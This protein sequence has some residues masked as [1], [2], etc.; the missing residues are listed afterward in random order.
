M[1]AAK[2]EQ[3]AAS[4]L[5]TG[6]ALLA[7]LA[8]AS[9]AACKLASYPPE[10][11]GPEETSALPAPPED[12][13]FMAAFEQDASALPAPREPEALTAATQAPVAA[14]QPE[15]KLAPAAGPAPAATEASAEA[16]VTTPA[17]SQP[18][19]QARSMT[20]FM[21]FSERLDYG[22]PEESAFAAA[23]RRAAAN[24]YEDRF[25]RSADAPLPEA[26]PVQIA[27]ETAPV[28]TPA[29]APS[30]AGERSVAEQIRLNS[31]RM[32]STVHLSDLVSTP[33]QEAAS[34]PTQSVETLEPAAAP[35]A[36]PDQ[37]ATEPDSEAREAAEALAGLEAAIGQE[38]WGQPQPEAETPE[39]IDVSILFS[40]P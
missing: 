3:P 17:P 39:E 30:A 21:T 11:A 25:A 38:I 14:A 18:T 26:E 6:L 35:D 7:A 31:A 29:A 36:G 4:G 16:T 8:L 28:P 20:R 2:S 34:R 40:M 10:G 12:Q 5:K 37:A 33:V 19:A 13:R 27:A 22:R 1:T 15:A 9:V 32:P 24:D 23:L